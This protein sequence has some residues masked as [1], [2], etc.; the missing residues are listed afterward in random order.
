VVYVRDAIGRITKKTETVGGATAVYEYGY[1]LAGRLVSV[2]ENGVTVSTYDYDANGN[3][4]TAVTKAGTFQGFYD[5]QDRM[6]K[7]GD[8]DYTYTANGELTTKTDSAGV[9]S[10]N[11]DVY[12]N[13][14]AA[15]LPDGTRIDYVI[16]AS[17]RRVG[18]KVNGALVQGFIY[19]NQLEPIAELDGAGNVISTFVYASKGH[20]PDYMVKGG[21]TY[22]IIS[23][24][25]GSVRL[26]I[27]TADNS[28]VQRIDYDEFGNVLQDTNPGFQPFAFAGGIYDQHTKLTRFGAR[29]FDAFAGR[30]TSKDPIR[31]R[32]GDLNLFEYVYGNPTNLIDI[33]GLDT[34]FGVQVSIQVMGFVGGGIGVAYV[35]NIT[36][37][38]GCFIGFYL[39]KMGGEVSA[40][41]AGEVIL[42]LN[43][44]KCGSN[45]PGTTV[46]IGFSA[47]TPPKSG[48][49]F[50]G[51]LGNDKSGATTITGGGTVGGGVG[52]G[53]N[54]EV[55]TI[56]Y[57]SCKKCCD[58]R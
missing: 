55:S 16:D 20:V 45:L 37:G 36:T 19:K 39:G 23:D 11:Y 31:F 8:A 13:L 41:I 26:V 44:P 4:I 5:L 7:Y 58:E 56:A 6:T 27:N 25:L 30:W 14:R 48:P 57:T 28:M 42:I 53:A 17:N 15:T 49:G 35:N 47:P 40:Y 38:E 9:T 34:W 18:K 12:G 43:G 50:S 32:S 29:D 24:H 22:R 51:S 3:R 46:S 2:K 33:S 21:V 10:Y 54:A 1:D 52:G